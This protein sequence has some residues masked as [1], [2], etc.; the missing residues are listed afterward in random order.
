M[1]LSYF[2][3]MS[4]M[5]LARLEQSSHQFYFLKGE[6]LYGKGETVEHVSIVLAGQFKVVLP[7]LGGSER[8]ISVARQGDSFGE[9]EVLTGTPSPVTLIAMKES[10]ILAIE[11]STLLDELERNPRLGFV[12]LRGLSRQ[13]HHQLSCME[14]S[15]HRTSIERVVLYLR[16]HAM[17]EIHATLEFELPALKAEIAAELG[18]APETFSRA[19]R[20]LEREGALA[21]KKRRVRILDPARLNLLDRMHSTHPSH[22]PFINKETCPCD[23]ENAHCLSVGFS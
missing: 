9:A 23:T 12:V 19:L 2:H 15:Q 5:S 20:G 17:N 11:R 4:D 1:R 3:G 13:L 8:I 18:M 21:I 14:V 7:S 22:T 10:R 6:K 16:N